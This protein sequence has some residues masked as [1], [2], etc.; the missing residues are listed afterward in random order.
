LF[1]QIFGGGVLNAM[2]S[3]L[4]Q[5]REQ[6]GLFYAIGGSLA[7]GANEQPG[8]VLVKTLVSL[9]RLA[10]AQELIKKTIDESVN[11]I[12][13]EEFLQARLAIANSLVN[14]FESNAQMAA[15]FLFLDK[16]SLPTDYFDKRAQ[17]LKKITIAQMQEV[18]KKVLKSNNMLMVRVGRVGK[19]E[20][21]QA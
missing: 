21:A 6:S 9:D 4:I 8:K 14:H 12:T 18:V 15:A 5:L 11:S 3:R 10:Q 16:Y 17:E 7:S 20:S 1:D 2:G 19:K 13:D